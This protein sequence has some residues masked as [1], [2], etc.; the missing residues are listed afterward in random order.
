MHS[1][2][3]RSTSTSL[4][5]RK[6]TPNFVARAWLGDAYA[7]G[8]EFRGRTRRI[9]IT[10]NVPMSFLAQTSRPAESDSQQGRAGASVLS[11]GDAIRAGES[12]AVSV[13]SRRS[14][15][16]GSTR[17][18]DK[19]DDVRRDSD[20]VWHTKAGAKVRVRLT[21]VAPS[22]RYHVALVDPIPA[23]LEAMNPELAVTGNIPQDPNSQELKRGL[24]VEPAVV[25]ASEHA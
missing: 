7:G 19:A 22:R 18:V 25:R 17:R 3:W 4:T 11:R 20:G 9:A 1:F 8:H 10:L 12:E 21:M 14:R 13:G 5:L 2:C 23:G 6:V 15:S 24:V 16:N